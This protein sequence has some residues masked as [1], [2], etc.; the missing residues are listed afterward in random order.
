MSVNPQNNSEWL[1]LVS[2]NYKKEYISD[3][4]EVI[5][6]P[7]S[8][9]VHFR[10]RKK[11]VNSSLWDKLPVKEKLK[12]GDEIQRLNEIK[13]RKI[14]IVFLCQDDKDNWLSSYPVRFA[15]IDKCYVTGRSDHDIAHFYLYVDSYCS[16]KK[17]EERKNFLEKIKVDSRE[18][19]FN[20]SRMA[21]LAQNMSNSLVQDKTLQ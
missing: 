21:F 1:I 20:N 15:T 11:W 10:Y 13:S 12:N 14:L 9:I 17:E 6:V 4:V 7:N 3:I 5:G 19:G 8:F 2:S 18:A 16:A